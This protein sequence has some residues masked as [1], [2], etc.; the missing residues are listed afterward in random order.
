[1]VGSSLVTE[2]ELRTAELVEEQ[3]RLS[4][5]SDP[6]GP[7]G[8]KGD[9]GRRVVCDHYPRRSGTRGEG[10]D[11]A[12]GLQPRSPPFLLSQDGPGRMHLP[13]FQA[14]TSPRPCSHYPHQDPNPPTENM[15][16]MHSQCTCCAHSGPEIQIDV[17]TLKTPCTDT[18]THACTRA[19][20]NGGRVLGRALCD[21]QNSAQ[22]RG[23]T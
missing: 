23:L 21:P 19:L 15:S 2:Q 18:H 1:M 8:L 22:Q 14:H 10:Q 5:C 3:N 7:V 6:Q 12:P 4:C 9:K 13:K 17:F 16:E 11:I 20:P